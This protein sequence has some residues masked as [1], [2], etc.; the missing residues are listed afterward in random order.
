MPGLARGLPPHGAARAL[1]LLR[2][3]HPHRRLDVQPARQVAEGLARDL[4]AAPA[5]LAQLPPQL[6][7]LAAGS[8]RVLT[9]G[10]GLHRPRRQQEGRDHPRLPAARRQL[11]ALRHGPLPAQ[12]PLRQRHRRREAARARSPLDGGGDRALHE[13]SRDLGV[14]LERRGCRARRRAWLLRRRAD[15]RD[16][17]RDRAPARAPSRCRVRVVN[18]VDLMRL[19]PESEHPHGLSDAISMRSSPRTSRSSS[20]TTAIRG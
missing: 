16:A 5:A 7:R 1:Q 19:Q 14:G 2:G 17:R 8:Q 3:V 6:A 11:P 18:V 13:G 4:L 15:A 9:P 20:P 12:P 10:P